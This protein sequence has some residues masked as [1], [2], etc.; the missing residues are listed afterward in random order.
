MGPDFHPQRIFSLCLTSIL[1]YREN[2][3]NRQNRSVLTARAIKI[4][5]AG[6]VCRTCLF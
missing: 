3:D 6:K 2:S 1:H 4:D 5:K